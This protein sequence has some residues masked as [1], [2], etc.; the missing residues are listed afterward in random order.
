MESCQRKRRTQAVRKEEARQ[1]GQVGMVRVIAENNTVRQIHV[2]DSF[3]GC[4]DAD[5]AAHNSDDLNIF[6]P[7]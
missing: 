3:W 5:K 4:A 6:R 2:K 7:D 1:D